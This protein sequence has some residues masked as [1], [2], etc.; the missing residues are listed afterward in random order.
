MPTIPLFPLNTVL[1]PG[2]GLPLQIFEERYLL[3]I[4][5]C[6]EESMPFGVALIRSGPEVG[7]RATPFAIGATAR[8]RQAERMPNGRIHILAEGVQRFRILE[9]MHDQPYLTGAVEYLEDQ[10]EDAPGIESLLESA[11][12]LFTDYTRLLL[13]ANGE[14]TRSVGLP[15][16]PGALA[17]HIAARIELDT[18]TK[19]R[20]LEE[21]RAP[22]RLGFVRRALEQGIELAADRAASAHSQRFGGFGALN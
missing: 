9:T 12:G 15:R 10:D 21:L 11:R 17:D 14:W 8:I 16:R 19:Q 22:E 20:L 6:L 2:A 7:G 5:R 13:Q 4:G 18:G 1:F 3:M